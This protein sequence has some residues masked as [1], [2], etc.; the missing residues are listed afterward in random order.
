[1]FKKFIGGEGKTGDLLPAIPSGCL[2]RTHLGIC[3]GGEMCGRF[4]GLFS[5]VKGPSF[6]R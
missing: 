4:F 1:M 3:V 2:M 6:R 5:A